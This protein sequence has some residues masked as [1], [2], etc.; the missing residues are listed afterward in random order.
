VQA[1]RV[2]GCN[3]VVPREVGR[4]QGEERDTGFYLPPGPAPVPE[5]WA[6]AVGPARCAPACVTLWSIDEAPGR[7]A[8]SE[9]TVTR[10]TPGEPD[11]ACG[12]DSDTT[13]AH[14]LRGDDG[15][16]R[17]L[18]LPRFPDQEWQG[19]MSLAGVL[20][21][22]EV[23]RVVMF[24]D[25]AT[26]AAFDLGGDGTLAG[27]RRVSYFVPHEED[28]TFRSLAPYCGP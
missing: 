4:V 16:V 6:T 17:P 15:A 13:F 21:D 20:A 3:L 22:G 26:W 27:G 7:P 9:A 25:V 23:P 24:T 1:E 28:F 8:I 10:I 14:Y 5:P 2:D 19:D 11:E 18:P 12:W